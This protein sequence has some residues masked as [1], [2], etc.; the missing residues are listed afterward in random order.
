MSSNESPARLKWLGISLASLL[1]LV[2][3]VATYQWWNRP[4]QMGTSDESF[5]TVDALYTAV[6]SHDDK[7]LRECEQRL[8]SYRQ[9][10]ELPD[11]AANSLDAIIAQAKAGGW[12]SATERL[13]EFML[14]QR[15]DG[16]I[17]K[18]KSPPSKSKRT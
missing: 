7:R 13:Y 12:Q 9:S 3:A 6:R 2:V 14:A 17:E 8:Q 16:V 5:K 11:A 15:R 1:T 18:T 10:G 4:P